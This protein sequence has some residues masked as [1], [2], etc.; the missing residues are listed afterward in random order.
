MHDGFGS[1]NRAQSIFNPSYPDKVIGISSKGER[2]TQG[3]HKNPDQSVL[4]YSSQ[5][6]TS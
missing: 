2:P 5:E 1:V 3:L 6:S 4:P